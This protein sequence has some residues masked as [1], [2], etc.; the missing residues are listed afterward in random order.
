MPN[1]RHSKSSFDYL[2]KLSPVSGTGIISTTKKRVDFL[3]MGSENRRVS[4]DRSGPLVSG[5][6]FSKSRRKTIQTDQ[7]TK[8]S[9]AQ[10]SRTA[11]TSPLHREEHVGLISLNGSPR[12]STA[13]HHSPQRENIVVDDFPNEKSESNTMPSHTMLTLKT[14]IDKEEEIFAR[15]ENS[16]IGTPSV[17]TQ[18]WKEKHVLGLHLVPD[19]QPGEYENKLKG[20]PS[21]QDHFDLGLDQ[22]YLNSAKSGNT[23]KR[24]GDYE[25]YE[26][27]GLP[28]KS[29]KL[30]EA[31]KVDGYSKNSSMVSIRKGNPRNDSLFEENDNGE[32]VNYLSEA[33]N[34]V[35]EIQAENQMAR[36]RFDSVEEEL[37]MVSKILTSKNSAFRH[38]TTKVSQ[39]VTSLE[40]EREK[41]ADAIASLEKEVEYMKKNLSDRLLQITELEDDARKLKEAVLASTVEIESLRNKFITACKER[42]D[43]ELEKTSLISE[44]ESMSDKIRRLEESL[45]EKVLSN[46]EL[47]E[48]FK[49]LVTDTQALNTEMA[50]FENEQKSLK[51][52]LIKRD[53]QIVSLEQAQYQ[54]RQEKIICEQKSEKFKIVLNEM[55]AINQNLTVQLSEAQKQVCDLKTQTEEKDLIISGDT[56]KLKD[57]NLQVNWQESIIAEL[58]A[59]TKETSAGHEKSEG[60]LILQVEILKGQISAAQQKSDERIQEIAEQLYHQYSKKHEVKVNQLRKNYETKMEDKISQI[61]EHEKRIENLESQLRMEIKEKEYLFSVLEKGGND[62]A[63]GTEK[64]IRF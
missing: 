6:A 61:R 25:V 55:E 60:E 57:L 50:L 35:K 47:G 1:S 36:A 23:E 38:F 54:I 17:H 49:S 9:T 46:Q 30:Q 8:G 41:N 27:E 40:K 52:D 19:N 15:D 33:I 48:K 11:W 10:F 3:G 26:V 37:N 20:S 53:E 32:Q 13:K 16:I 12:E 39:T 58:R 44:R 31:L 45:E 4:F 43:L 2:Y 5:N 21:F 42:D 62:G 51:N 14:P 56:E 34:K 7:E 24:S 64:E 59:E 29:Q 18:E 63:G 28:L 22:L